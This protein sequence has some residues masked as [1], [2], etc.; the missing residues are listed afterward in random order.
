MG[1][2]LRDFDDGASGSLVVRLRLLLAGFSD[3]KT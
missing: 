3:E 1:A 2:T